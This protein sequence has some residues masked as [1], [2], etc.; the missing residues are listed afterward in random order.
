MKPSHFLGCLPQALVLAGCSEA[1]PKAE[2]KEPEPPP[3]PISAQSALRAMWIQARAWS[4]DAKPLRV[5]SINL[6]E[7]PSK[8][9]KAGAWDATF[10]SESRGRTRRY[11]Y[12]VVEVPSSNLHKGVFA[13]PEDSWSSGGQTKPITM[14][15]VKTD[16]TAAL[17]TALEKGGADYS[18]KNPDLPITFLLEFTRRF[19]NPAWRVIWGESVSR[20]NFSVFVDATTGKYLE[21]AR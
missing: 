18:A 9:G 14:Q 11:T 10:V 17:T 12:S 1:P 13:G 8:D 15:E 2:V 16:S 5:A 7:V 20:S 6:T 4:P 3:E 19:P 21:T